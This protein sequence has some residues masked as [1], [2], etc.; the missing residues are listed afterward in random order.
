[1]RLSVLD[2]CPVSAGS[3][4]A[5]ALRNTVELARL[6][7]R[8]GYERYW[9]AE[10]HATET[11]ASPAPEVLLG[12]LG[13]ETERLRIGSGGIML[14]HYSPLKVAEQ[15]RMLHALYPQ[16][17]DLGIGRAPGGGPLETFALRR[18]R[19]ETP[20]PDDFPDQLIELLGF[21]HR[22]FAPRHPFSRIKVS[23][24]MPGA[25]V[26]WL[27]GSS[28]WSASAAAQ[29]GLPYAFAHFIAPQSTR[30]AIEQ[31]RA[32]FEPS[33]YLAEPRVI[34][35]LG[36]ICAA[37]EA[38]AE[39]LSSSVRL[40]G[41][42]LR[43]GDLRPVP[44][45]EEAERELSDPGAVFPEAQSEWPRHLAGSPGGLRERL[46]EVARALGLDE[47]MIVTIVHDHRA[48]L[49]SYELLARAFELRR[50]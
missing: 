7:D 33:R 14:P 30:A 37:T 11:L 12:R 19:L 44:T 41:R 29:L 34:V 39:R 3:S 27:L 47:L 15:F 45:V 32:R 5:E 49:H 2:Q 42:R 20:M 22:E 48:R 18:E 36:A 31:Y 6:A 4:P 10:H 40:M 46:A 50:C 8:L 28:L 17:V 43:Q 16:R 24:E 1:M 13:A 9:I 23:P 26:V 38:E 21:L 35:A 25:P